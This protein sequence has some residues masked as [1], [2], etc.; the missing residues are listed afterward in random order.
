[1]SKIITPRWGWAFTGSGH[2]FN[3][4]VELVRDLEHVDLFLSKAA[5]EVLRQYPGWTLPNVMGAGGL[6]ALVKSGLPAQGKRQS[7][8]EGVAGLGGRLRRNSRLLGYGNRLRDGLQMPGYHR[9]LMTPGRAIGQVHNKRDHVGYK[10]PELVTPSKA[11]VIFNVLILIPS[12]LEMN[13]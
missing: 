8:I 2:F 13:V 9:L 10:T 6:Q 5:A 1:M 3:E 11:R 7:Y 12:L 4:C